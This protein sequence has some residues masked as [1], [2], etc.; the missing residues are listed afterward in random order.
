MFK[1]SL[2]I[3]YKSLQT[4][5]L[6]KAQCDFITR[7][8][9]RSEESISRRLCLSTSVPPPPSNPI[10]SWLKRRRRRK[11][12]SLL[13]KDC[14]RLTECEQLLDWTLFLLIGHIIWSKPETENIVNDDVQWTL[15]TSVTTTVTH[16]AE[17][18]SK[19]FGSDCQTRC[20][21]HL[22][23][24]PAKLLFQ[25]SK[26]EDGTV[27]GWVSWRMNLTKQHRNSTG[28]WTNLNASKR[29]RQTSPTIQTG[30]TQP[31]T[32]IHKVK[33]EV[34]FLLVSPSTRQPLQ[35]TQLLLC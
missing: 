28:L 7:L 5:L 2:Q 19:W 10:V 23:F 16:R 26:N 29:R 30:Q 4:S 21:H 24:D 27:N 35:P 12:N 34:K 32:T 17:F 14:R 22:H 31:V 1:S 33:N 15:Q 11:N 3:S 13:R 9:S 18:S 25:T 6:W 8:S 20:E